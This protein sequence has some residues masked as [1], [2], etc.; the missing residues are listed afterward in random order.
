MHNYCAGNVITRYLLFWHK[1]LQ[2]H[3][4]TE[5][6]NLI[7]SNTDCAEAHHLC[8]SY[9]I[10]CQAWHIELTVSNFALYD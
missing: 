3:I 10:S 9:V 5:R 6:R 1:N 7:D 2:K 4:H 8:G